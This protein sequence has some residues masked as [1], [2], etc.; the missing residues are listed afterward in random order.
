M[1]DTNSFVNDQLNKTTPTYVLCHA[2]L[3]KNLIN[4]A[5]NKGDE[6]EYIPCA[7]EAAVMSIA[8]GLGWEV[9]NQ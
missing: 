9:K 1:L 6:L 2:V 5:I 4:A 3:Q 7:S 8:A